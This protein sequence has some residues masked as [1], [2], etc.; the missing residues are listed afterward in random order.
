MTDLQR[1]LAEC[2]E[3]LE[4][5]RANLAGANLTCADLEDAKDDLFKILDSAPNEVAGLLAALRSGRVDG[6][7]YHGECACL[8]GTIANVRGVD[9]DTLE[10]NSL[11]PAE[12]WFLAI[13][14]GDTPE[15]NA[16]AKITA[17]WIDEWIA[18][19]PSA[20]A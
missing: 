8:V 16:V 13:R 4:R 19:Q 11:R 17:E 15:T 9:V 2:V 5:A 6:S 10:Q 7:T 3:A 1:E 20:A 12:R 18:S 14:K